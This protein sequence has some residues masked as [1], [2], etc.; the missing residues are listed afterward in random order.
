MYVSKCDGS[1][2]GKWG[3][4]GEGGE[5]EGVDEEGEMHGGVWEHRAFVENLREELNLGVKDG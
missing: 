3:A 4:E 5:E 2:V 1:R